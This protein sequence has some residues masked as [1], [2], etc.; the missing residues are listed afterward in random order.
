MTFP[1]RTS[2]EELTRPLGLTVVLTVALL[3]SFVGGLLLVLAPW[4]VPNLRSHLPALGASGI[5][6]IALILLC[7][8]LWRHAGWTW[9][10]LVV[11][12]YTVGVL[13]LLFAWREPEVVSRLQGTVMALHT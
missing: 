1:G 2:G 11:P 6:L 5:A 9:W 3:A 4:W 12:A 13:G 7:L 8:G 10:L